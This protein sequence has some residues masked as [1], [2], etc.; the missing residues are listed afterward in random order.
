MTD[1]FVNT[2]LFGSLGANLAEFVTQGDDS[3]QLQLI[4]ACFSG[5]AVYLRSIHEPFHTRINKTVINR[6]RCMVARMVVCMGAAQ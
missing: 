6:G 5:L 2:R 3:D 1:M 4:A